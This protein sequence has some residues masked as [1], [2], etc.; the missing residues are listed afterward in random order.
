MLTAPASASAPTSSP[1]E[2]ATTTEVSCPRFS[3]TAMVFPKWSPASFAPPA[4]DWLTCSLVVP[5][6]MAVLGA[7]DHVDR[8]GV[9]L[10]LVR[11]RSP[12][13]HVSADV[14]VDVGGADRPA[15]VVPGC[16]RHAEV[17]DREHRPRALA[18]PVVG[19]AVQHD[20]A[21]G[22]DLTGHGGVR[23]AHHAS[24]CPSPLMSCVPWVR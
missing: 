5:A 19:V 7:V 4:S 1:G 13:H 17:R 9:H 15:E 6:L 11:S 21:A 22:A 12:D 14:H 2:P 20:D 18:D 24:V 8:P 3:P 10:G 16:R 23:V